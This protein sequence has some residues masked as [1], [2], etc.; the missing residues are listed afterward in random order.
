MKRETNIEFAELF[1]DI[2]EAIHAKASKKKIKVL[3]FGP[4]ITRNK[5]SAKLR[6]YIISKC[7]KHDYTVVLAEHEEIRKLYESIFGSAND[8]CN[9]EYHLA[10]EKIHRT[11][12]DIID[13]IVIIPDSVGSFIELGM[14]SINDSIH[15]KVLILF[16]KNFESDISNRFIGLGA[17]AAYDNGNAKTRILNYEDKKTAWDEV[18]G[19][20]DFHKGKK[21]LKK[22]KN[23]L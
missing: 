13:V 7:K 16:N 9:M 1:Q 10:T 23:R 3:V 20:L 17:K 12:E 21:L 19:F 15:E 22:V 6:K 11:K 8:L 2:R 4:D 18:A 5:A 14:L